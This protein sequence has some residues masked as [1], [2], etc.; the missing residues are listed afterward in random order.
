MKKLTGNDI[1]VAHPL[2]GWQVRGHISPQQQS[3]EVLRPQAIL[4]QHPIPLQFLS[5]IM[6]NLSSNSLHGRL[7]GNSFLALI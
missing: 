6:Q 1:F 4:I 2:M 7:C 3:Q 5:A